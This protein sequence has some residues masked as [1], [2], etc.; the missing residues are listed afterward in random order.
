[1][2][3]LGSFRQVKQHGPEVAWSC[4]MKRGDRAKIL[5]SMRENCV[6]CGLCL[7]MCLGWK[8]GQ[9]GS[10][11]SDTKYDVQSKKMEKLSL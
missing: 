6:F 5:P 4:L 10:L 7:G 1:M 8:V 11:S 9:E 3:E 2:L